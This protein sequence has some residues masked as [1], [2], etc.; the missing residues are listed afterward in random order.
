MIFFPL[1]P[2]TPHPN[3]KPPTVLPREKAILGNDLPVVR[4]LIMPNTIT[5]APIPLS[6]ASSVSAGVDSDTGARPAPQLQPAMS[7]Q[8]VDSRD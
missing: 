5:S 2:S 4:M 6:A 1:H 8:R 3:P 7:R